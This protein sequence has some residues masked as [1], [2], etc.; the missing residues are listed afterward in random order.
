MKAH[1]T[2]G[3]IGH[4]NHGKT[5]IV[6]ALTGIDTDRLEE[7]KRRGMSIVL[8]FAHLASEAGSIDLVDVPGHEQFVRTMV[9]GATGIDASLLVVNA[10]EG[11]KPQT[12][13]HVAIA[14][15][16]GVRR[17]VVA[18]TKSDLVEPAQR[19]AV[20]QRVRSFLRGTHLEFSPV[21]FTS[22]VLGEGFVAL[23][24]EL[25]RLLAGPRD[26]AAGHGRFW[27]PV[28]RVFTLPGHGTIATGTLRGATLRVGE[29]VG[30]FPRGAAGTVRQLQVHGEPVDEAHPGQRVGVNLRHLDAS[31]VTR[32][33]VLAPPAS[34]CTTVRIDVA[35]QLLA[36]VPREQVDGRRV[37]LLF[38]TTEVGAR[39]RV[40]ASARPPLLLAQ[41]RTMRP[42]VAV[43]GEAFILRRESPAATLAGGRI[44][45]TAARR[46]AR[47][48]AAAAERLRILAGGSSRQRLQERLRAAGVG[49]VALDALAG[50]SGVAPGQLAGELQ[51]IAF[52]QAGR[53]WHPAVVEDLKQRVLRALAQSHA[54]HPL[55]PA[56]PLSV[57]RAALPRATPQALQRCVLELLAGEQRIV[58]R[59]GQAALA[60][61]DPLRSL[62]PASRA[63]L[64]E[65]A[66]SFRAGGMQPPDPPPAQ[67]EPGARALLDLLVAQGELLLLPGQPP[68]Q[69]IAFHRDA[70]AAARDRLAAAFPPPNPFTVSEARA[71]LGS[72]R[73][74]TVPLLQYLHATGQ[75]RR[76]GDLHAFVPEVLPGGE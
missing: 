9:A 33:D 37:R 20:Q 47:A 18:I 27:L 24:E 72:T 42:V 43:A 11:I 69:R 29:A 58:L 1:A 41:L 38:G 21:V 46:H 16:L 12:V 8:G 68:T 71:L 22:T 60:Q 14:G 28:D 76:R 56:A 67:G 36:E 70:L 57:L 13:E 6:R 30:A 48:D 59:P 26:T 35:L 31:A 3:V 17:G 51:G 50:E 39:V 15:L 53:L 54:A 65:L 45:D 73:K 49:G 2:V 55:R 74:F 61:H 32:G 40:L 7:E 34:L 44:L 23:R 62:D 66:A 10:R 5:S 52:V 63:R 64:R 25:L 75:T 19:A 4:V